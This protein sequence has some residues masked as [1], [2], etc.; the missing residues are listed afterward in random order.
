MHVTKKCTIFV[1]IREK[2]V[3]A[4]GETISYSIYRGNKFPGKMFYARSNQKSAINVLF[5]KH[6]IIGFTA[7]V[8]YDIAKLALKS[9]KYGFNYFFSGLV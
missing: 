9:P 1:T 8:D 7:D 4:F 6:S 2:N 3:V 5:D